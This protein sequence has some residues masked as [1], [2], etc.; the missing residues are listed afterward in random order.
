MKIETVGGL[1]QVE[2]TLTLSQAVR[3]RGWRTAENQGIRRF[4]C[5]RGARRRRFPKRN[6]KGFQS[7][8]TGNP[9]AV[10]IRIRRF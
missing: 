7:V 2:N 10:L 4:F 8:S 5:P 6:P 9:R 1:V 3:H